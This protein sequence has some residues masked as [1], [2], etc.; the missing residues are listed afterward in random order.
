MTDMENKLEKQIDVYEHEAMRKW[1]ERERNSGKEN[2]KWIK[3]GF[4][5]KG[6][7]GNRRTR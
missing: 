1:K 6:E 7:E 5:T 2:G 3:S 4:G